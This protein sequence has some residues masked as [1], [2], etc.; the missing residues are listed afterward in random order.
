METRLPSY[1]VP[2]WA[3]STEAP[4]PLLWGPSTSHRAPSP[5]SYMQQLPGPV[6]CTVWGPEVQSQP[7]RDPWISP[8]GSLLQEPMFW[9][10]RHLCLLQLFSRGRPLLPS[11]F[12]QPFNTFTANSCINSLLSEIAPGMSVFLSSDMPVSCVPWLLD[13]A[14]SGTDTQWALRNMC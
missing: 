2:A 10:T 9:K 6:I 13:P 11:G 3:S 8:V 12:S 4:D 1:H 5:Q 14:G 7:P